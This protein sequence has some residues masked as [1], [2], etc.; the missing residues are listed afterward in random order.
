MAGCPLV[1]FISWLTK[2]KLFDTVWISLRFFRFKDS[3]VGPDDNFYFLSIFLLPLLEI[4]SLSLWRMT[5]VARFK[6][7]II[8]NYHSYWVLSSNTKH[9]LNYFLNGFSNANDPLHVNWLPATTNKNPSFYYCS[10]PASQPSPGSQNQHSNQQKHQS[11]LTESRVTDG[12][13]GWCRLVQTSV[14]LSSALDYT[15]WRGDSNA[16]GHLS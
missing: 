3:R 1:C 10:G 6:L 14:R 7:S 2:I 9:W 13:A 4:L 8:P 11:E 5:A 12:S 15:D 16:V